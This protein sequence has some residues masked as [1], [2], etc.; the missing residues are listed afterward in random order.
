[1]RLGGTP[2]DRRVGARIRRMVGLGSQ[3][4]RIGTLRAVPVFLSPEWLR[5]L[6]AAAR[7]SRALA[8]DDTEALV[9][10]QRV[11]DA[12]GGDVTY[13]AVLGT[14]ARVV[15]GPADAP[16]V[17]FVT[18]YDTAFALRSGTLN[19]QHAI[20]AGRMKVQGHV[21]V[22][23]RKADTLRAFGDI[24]QDVRATTDPPEPREEHR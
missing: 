4:T 21:G 8:N 16:D 13:H 9:V 15:A 23:L 22:L 24:F 7:A 12:P 3:S 2:G 20:A 6:D 1:M 11:T 5:D 19:A 17:V 18:D 14:D 10:E